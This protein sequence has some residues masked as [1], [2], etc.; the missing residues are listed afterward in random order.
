MKPKMEHYACIVDLLGRA[1]SLELAL[2]I[3]LKMPEKP[4]SDVWVALLSSCRLH[5]DIEMAK[6]AANE[7]FKL[8]AND[9]PGAYVALSNTFA[10]A[11][12]WDSVTELREVMK[13]RGILKDTACSWVGSESG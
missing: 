1:G 4:N 13:L 8:N 9:R 6:I 5:G 2:E 3:V 10:A 12:K 11:G 7:I